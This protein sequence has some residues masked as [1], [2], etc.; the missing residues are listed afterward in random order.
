M[1][2]KE[3]SDP[4]V[5]VFYFSLFSLIAFLLL[6]FTHVP[7][8]GVIILASLST[9]LW[10]AGAYFMLKALKIGQASRVIPIIGT[11]TPVLLFIQ[12]LSTNSINTQQI[13][14]VIVLILGLVFLTLPDFKLSITDRSKLFFQ[15]LPLEIF[16]SLFFASSYLILRE[17]YLHDNFLTVLVW[18]RLILF[19]LGILLLIIPNTRKI[20]L[21]NFKSK[22]RAGFLPRVTYLF[23][24]GQAV[25]G[26]SELLLT[27][28]ISLAT[29][30]LV[31]SLQGVQYVFLFLATLLLAKKFPGVFTEKFSSKNIFVKIGGI[32][33]IGFGLYILAFAS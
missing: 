31:N 22:G 17:A 27:L 1:I 24:V 28:S 29:P 9:L 10:T 21:S 26:A 5:Y 15:E 18:S 32:I 30:A 19:P 4:L 23:L 11:L 33:L 12:A 16:A 20:I 6:P 8:L 3:F 25:G 2:T 13:L 14:A 7:M